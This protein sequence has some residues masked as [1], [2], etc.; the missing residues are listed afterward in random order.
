[1]YEIYEKLADTFIA[2]LHMA[3]AIIAFRKTG[4]IYGKDLSYQIS[5]ANSLSFCIIVSLVNGFTM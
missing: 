5:K 3:A 4:V 1:M 2:L